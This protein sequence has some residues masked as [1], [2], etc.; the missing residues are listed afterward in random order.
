MKT[1]KIILISLAVIFIIIAVA[2]IIK[3]NFINDDVIISSESQP[4]SI[5]KTN[6]PELDL[7]Q[8]DTS[9]KKPNVIQADSSLSLSSWKLVET[10]DQAKFD[11]KESAFVISF[12]ASKNSFST[13]T[14]CN[15]GFGSF[16]VEGNNISFGDIASTMM[17][18]EGSFEGTY[19]EML[20]NASTYTLQD[21]QLTLK[22]S[23]GRTMVFKKN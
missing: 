11:S 9:A 12:D 16:N 14:D 13:T 10:S 3:F 1:L 17:Y 19:F 22:L 5:V 20:S 6:N 21:D 8:T 2:G 7:T 15:N 18:C 4:D 23:D